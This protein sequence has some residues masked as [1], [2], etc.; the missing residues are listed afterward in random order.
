MPTKTT[1]NVG[2]VFDPKGMKIKL[3][4]SDSTYE[5]SEDFTCDTT[6]PLTEETKN[7]EI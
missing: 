4:Y 2:E 7:V 6:T 5:I 3:N 1:Y